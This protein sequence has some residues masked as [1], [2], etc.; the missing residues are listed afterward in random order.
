MKS[1]LWHGSDKKKSI[2]PIRPFTTNAVT[3]PGGVKNGRVWFKEMK[4]LM[5][6]IDRTA[7]SNGSKT[8]IGTTL[9]KANSWFNA[10]RG[11]VKIPST[12]STRRKRKLDFLMLPT[13][14]R[15]FTIKE[16]SVQVIFWAL[17]ETVVISI[18]MTFL[19]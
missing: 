3:F 2:P 6:C 10:G 5:A 1:Q 13:I 4:R 19:Y 8:E 11:G 17:I 18:N 9:V 16:T 15:Y 7:A 14:V 12:M